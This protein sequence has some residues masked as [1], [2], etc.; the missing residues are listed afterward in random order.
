[1]RLSLFYTLSLTLYV[2]F[3]RLYMNIFKVISPSNLLAPYVKQYWF[4]DINDAEG[5]SQRLVPFGHIGIAFHLG[6]RA[7][8]LSANNYFPEAHIWGQ[9][10]DYREL[11]YKGHIKFIAI[12][13]QPAGAMY[14][15]GFPPKETDGQIIDIHSLGSRAWAELYERLYNSPGIATSI[16]LIENFLIQRI[17]IGNH[18]NQERIHTIITAIE[19]GENR[20]NVLADCA[21]LGKKQFQRIFSEQVGINPKEYIRIR[22]LQRAMLILQ[23]NPHLTL[24]QVSEECGYYDKSHFL[25]DMRCC[26]GL[27][28]KNFLTVCGTYSEYHALFRSAFIDNPQIELNKHIEYEPNHYAT[29]IRQLR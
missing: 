26:T 29:A 12:I 27:T 11:V 21:C 2:Y 23:K 24:T 7:F 22:R 20:I 3:C 28:P 19:S 15:L 1:M 13:L 17:R 6:E 25:K 8:S 18:S 4:L 14:V 16:R 9:T 10:T 5:S